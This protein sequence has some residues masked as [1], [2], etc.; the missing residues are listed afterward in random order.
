MVPICPYAAAFIRK[1]PE[2]LPYVRES[3]RGAMGA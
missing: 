3:Y 1:H 2:Y